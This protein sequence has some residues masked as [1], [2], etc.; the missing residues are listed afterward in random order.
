VTRP[1]TDLDPRLAK[2]LAHPLRI[3]ILGLLEE[4]SSTPKQ[5]A[6]T[7]GVP[8]GN[9]SYHVR[10]LRDNGFLELEQT[11]VVRGAVEHRYRVVVRPHITAE[12]WAELPAIVREALDTANVTRIVDEVGQALGEDRF[13]HPD[14]CLARTAFELDDEGF[15]E[16]SRLISETF[17][18][19][20]A[21]EARAKERHSGHPERPA[22]AVA[23]LFDRPSERGE[24]LHSA[25]NGVPGQ[26][27][28]TH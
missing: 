8:L 10:A 6:H 23:M 12:T 4:G 14:S 18:R 2:A 16:A 27:A 25:G 3:R 19:L 24:S 11:R 28:S 7:L 5:L 13:S 26:V 21:I 1:T 20:E 15:A 9:V 17:D 22:V